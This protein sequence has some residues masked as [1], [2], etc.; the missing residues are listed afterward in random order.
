MLS[1]N[2]SL[3]IMYIFRIKVK[4]DQFNEQFNN[5]VRSAIGN[6]FLNNSSS[7]LKT[8]SF[9][10]LTEVKSQHSATF[11]RKAITELSA[12][13]FLF[14]DILSLLDSRSS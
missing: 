2:F 8:L 4:E 12:I 3:Y 11:R 13:N 1:C 5:F 14:F 9:S 7:Q 10:N 6:T